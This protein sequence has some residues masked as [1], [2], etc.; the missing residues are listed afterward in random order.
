MW[1]RPLRRDESGSRDTKVP[2]TFRRLQLFFLLQ[3]E[4]R[5]VHAI[6]KTSRFGPIGK[7]VAEMAAATR[8]QNLGARHHE[9]ATGFRSH[10]ILRDRLI[11]TRPSAPR[12]ELRL[13]AEQRISAARTF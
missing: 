2:P 7:D 10:S 8:T 11:E 3:L 1:E 5:G 4:R 6:T 12:F 13:R 9:F